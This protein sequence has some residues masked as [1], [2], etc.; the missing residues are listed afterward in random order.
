[1][2]NNNMIYTGIGSRK[3]PDDILAK[4][5]K[6]GNYFAKQNFTLRSG[7]AKGADSAFELGCDQ[8][9]G[10][11]EIFLPWKNFENKQSEFY[12][13][14]NEALDIAKRFH[15]A[16]NKLKQGA[17]KLH[18]RNCYQILGY[19]LKTP[20][21]FVLCY[22]GKNGGTQQ[23]LRVAKE[24]NIP[25]FNMINNDWNTRLKDFLGLK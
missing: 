2:I 4:M 10:N 14:S 1:M 17:Q 20:T 7:G 21:N 6:I 19:D 24:Y 15:P 5:V 23:A 3:S 8:A 13:I 18:A 25:I 11:K 12:E 16:W 22:T 9:S